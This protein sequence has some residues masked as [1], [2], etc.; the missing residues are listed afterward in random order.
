MV[1][2]EQGESVSVDAPSQG[3]WEYRDSFMG[4]RLLMFLSQAPGNMTKPGADF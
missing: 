3:G 1:A 2:V 4:I